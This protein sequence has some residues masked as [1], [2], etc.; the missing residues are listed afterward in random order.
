MRGAG[1]VFG[2]FV[3][4]GHRVEGG[5]VVGGYGVRSGGGGGG[6][7]GSSAQKMTVFRRTGGSEGQ[8]TKLI[9]S[10]HH[11]FVGQAAR[12]T[13]GGGGGGGGQGCIG[14]GGGGTPPPAHPAYAQPLS[15]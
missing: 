9:R 11:V 8:G 1:A 14:T 3:F 6:E 7:G 13:P 4:R 15:P 2:G 10:E 12:W 5:T